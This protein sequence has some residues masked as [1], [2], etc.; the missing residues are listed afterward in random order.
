MQVHSTSLY[1]VITNVRNKSHSYD[2]SDGLYLSE[3]TKNLLRIKY[4]NVSA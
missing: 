1:M 2:L 4:F 3:R